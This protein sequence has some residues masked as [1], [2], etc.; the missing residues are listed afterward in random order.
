VTEVYLARSTD[1]G[2]SFT[3]FK[4]S[5]SSFLPDA[6]VFFGDYSNIAAHNGMIYPMWMRMDQGILSVWVAIV[7]DSIWTDMGDHHDISVSD[8]QLYQNYPNPFNPTTTIRY[9]VPISGRMRL[10]IHDLLGREI[11]TLIDRQMPAGDHQ[12]VWDA[13]DRPSGIYY[14][15]LQA[16]NYQQV[17]K[18]I[19][20]K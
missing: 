6:S 13:T 16:E 4:V 14:F 19:L 5:E 17:K 15:R 12:V 10:T 8:F 2:E 7:A 11:S 3:N 9:H 18:M 20:I 1:G